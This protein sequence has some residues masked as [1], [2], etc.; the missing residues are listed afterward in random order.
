MNPVAKHL[1]PGHRGDKRYYKRAFNT[2]FIWNLQN[3][4]RRKIFD[5]FMDLMRP[6][7][8]HKI[9]DLGVANVPEPLEN[10]F[11]YY[12]PYKSQIVCAGV[13]NAAFLEKR[14]P[15]LKFIGVTPGARLP[16]ESNYFDVGFS[17]ATIEHVGSRKNQK[18]FLHEFL[19]VCKRIFIATPNRWY[20]FELHTR[21]PFIHWLPPSVFRAIISSIGFKFYSKE[22]NL[23]LLTTTDFMK[24]MPKGSCRIRHKKIYFLGFPS[25]LIFTVEKEDA[26]I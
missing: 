4:P 20:P 9:L 8:D 12:Y 19:R 23:N 21:L 16:F 14:Y 7:R 13:E 26:G 3:K 15:G 18:E 2:P 17:N 11:E 25:N 22:E 24:L 6:A 10:F 1:K 5:V